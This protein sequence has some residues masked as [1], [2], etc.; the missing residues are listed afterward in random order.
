MLLANGALSLQLQVTAHTLYD[1]SEPSIISSNFFQFIRDDFGPDTPGKE[2]VL[3]MDLIIWV[4]NSFRIHDDEV[5]LV[6]AP[7]LLG[8]VM[9]FVHVSMVRQ[10]IILR[11][12]RKFYLGRIAPRQTR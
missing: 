8:R 1:A 2:D 3:H 7:L 5:L 9:Q 10:M 12:L 11:R 6:H 4:L